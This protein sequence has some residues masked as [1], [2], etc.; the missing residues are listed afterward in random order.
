MSKDSP[1][2]GESLGG[3][4]IS[5]RVLDGPYHPSPFGSVETRGAG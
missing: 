5:A 1:D 3:A 2:A 4:K